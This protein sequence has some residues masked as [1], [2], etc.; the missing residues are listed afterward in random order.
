MREPVIVLV[1]RDLLLIRTTA[2]TMG[3]ID[4]NLE[5]NREKGSGRVDVEYANLKVRIAKR[6]GTREKNVFKSFLINQAIRS[7]NIRSDGNFRHGDFTVDRLKDRQIFN[8]MWR[9]LR[10]GMM[11][12]VLPQVLKDAQAALKTAKDVTKGK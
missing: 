6:D 1:V 7:K 9:G 8:Y 2:G 11:E 12:T 5:A 4:Y 10:Q 3:G